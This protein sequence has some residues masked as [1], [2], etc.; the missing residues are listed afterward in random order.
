MTEQWWHHT[1]PF[2]NDEPDEDTK[3]CP[4]IRAGCVGSACIFHVPNV[5]GADTSCLVAE[6]LF[7]KVCGEYLEFGG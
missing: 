2:L 5:P 1:R 7:L 4:M 6:Y 3:Y